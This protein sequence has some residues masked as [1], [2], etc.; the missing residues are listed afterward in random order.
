MTFRKARTFL[1][2]MGIL[3]LKSGTVAKGTKLYYY[4]RSKNKRQPVQQVN[5]KQ[6]TFKKGVQLKKLYIGISHFNGDRFWKKWFPDNTFTAIKNLGVNMLIPWGIYSKK[7]GENV[8]G[9]GIKLARM[10]NFA[11][12]KIPKD[13]KS[14]DKNGRRINQPS[15]CVYQSPEFKIPLKK[16]LIFIKKDIPGFP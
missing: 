8:T 6:I 3:K 7:F 14:V 5:I 10:T 9:N 2:L 16:L 1:G 15:L 13:W 11:H 12:M 4:A